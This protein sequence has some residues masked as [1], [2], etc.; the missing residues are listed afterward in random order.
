MIKSYFSKFISFDALMPFMGLL[1]II[2][3]GLRLLGSKSP[4]FKKQQQKFYYYLLIELAVM[5]IVTVIVY[6]LR[7][8]T[9]MLRYFSLMGFAF[10]VG[11]LHVYFFRSS[12]KKFD[13][14]KNFREFMFALVTAAVLVIPILIIGAHFDD[15]IFLPYYF[16]VVAA[17]VVPTSFYMLFN[18]SVSIP[19]KLYSKWYYPLGKKYDTPKHYELSNMIVLN[20]MFYKNPGAQHMTSFKAKAPKDM[21]FGRLFFFFINDYNDKKTTAKIEM[22]KDS[23][24]PYGWY[25]HTKP[26]W[27]GASKHIDS[28]LSVEKNHLEDG[29]VVVCQRI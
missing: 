16:L 15:L 2:F 7:Q 26:K 24:D 20:F 8:S 11:G 10:V 25:F 17:F 14:D 28:E 23:G 1:M 5:F 18:N 6:N 27:Y 9:L 3:V 12:F 29:H 21:K 22:T 13:S 4:G 19:V